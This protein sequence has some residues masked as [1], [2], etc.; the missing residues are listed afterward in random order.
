MKSN[1][2]SVLRLFI[3]F[4]IVFVLIGLTYMFRN[5]MAKSYESF[6]DQKCCPCPAEGEESPSPQ[7][8]PY[9]PPPEPHYNP[10]DYSMCK[11]IA[12][13]NNAN[14]SN[15]IPHNNKNV[16]TKYWYDASRECLNDINCH[17]FTFKTDDIG[18]SRGRTQFFNNFNP[19]KVKDSMWKLNDYVNLYH[20]TKGPCLPDPCNKD[21]V[22][23]GSGII[24]QPQYISPLQ[25]K[26]N[27][28][29]PPNVPPA[30]PG[31]GG[32]FAPGGGG[33]FIP[34][35]GGS[36]GFTPA[37]SGGGSGSGGFE[38]GSGG[39]FPNF[40]FVPTPGSGGNIDPLNPANID[41]SPFSPDFPRYP[42]SPGSPSSPVS[43]SSPGSPGSPSSPGSYSPTINP[44][45]FNGG[46][47]SCSFGSG[48]SGSLYNSSPLGIIGN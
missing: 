33:G 27:Q 40:P 7:P 28:F 24:V 46:M 18:D 12:T 48:R 6:Q 13:N 11:L 21:N 26:Q 9:V 2:N 14:N 5:S 19:V 16:S 35:G 39:N 43:P 10:S 30:Y 1:S 41:P 38:P 8:K 31:G 15:I 36:G 22:P 25:E 3:I 20:K 42:V 34:G 44:S 45:D 32:G 23:P 47:G 17:S 37:S 4:I 29:C